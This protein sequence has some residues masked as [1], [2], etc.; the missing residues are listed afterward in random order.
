MAKISNPLKPLLF[1]F[2]NA[3]RVVLWALYKPWRLGLIRG[4]LNS[5]H[6]SIESQLP[7]QT[8]EHISAFWDFSGERF[9]ELSPY[10]ILKR[11]H[12]YRPIIF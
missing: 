4:I 3:Q 2:I 5:N 6:L 11:D 8:K 9:K 1:L 10:L 12:I 7:S